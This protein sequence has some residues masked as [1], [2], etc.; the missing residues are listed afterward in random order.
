MALT[1]GAAGIPLCNCSGRRA[2]RCPSRRLL[3][4]ATCCFIRWCL[5]D[6]SPTCS[7]Y[8]AP[9]AGKFGAVGRRRRIPRRRIGP[10]CPARPLGVGGQ[11]LS[12]TGYGSGRAS[13]FLDL[14]VLAVTAGMAAVPGLARATAGDLMLGLV[15]FA[16]ADALYA[17]RLAND[18]F[19]GH[20]ARCRLDGRSL[21][22]RR[23]GPAL[24][25]A[26]GKSRGR[27][28]RLVDACRADGRDGCRGRGADRGYRPCCAGTRRRPRGRNP[29]VRG[30]AQPLALRKLVTLAEVRRQSRTDELT[31]RPEPA[32]AVRRRARVARRKAG[33]GVRLS[34]AGRGRV[35]GN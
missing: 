1:A 23:L 27:Q 13:P 4:V 17:F 10:G 35:K 30:Y 3:M 6:C 14:I 16:V 11:R 2:P 8:A 31:G 24:R 5:A 32:C 29:P 22:R 19:A 20:T 9:K 12:H 26:G 28:R 7:L 25:P 33:N 21:P 18:T 15:V 34:A